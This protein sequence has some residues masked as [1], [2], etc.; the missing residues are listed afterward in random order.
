MSSFIE[1][2]KKARKVAIWSIIGMIGIWIVLS[3]FS[4][5]DSE[6]RKRPDTGNISFNGQTALKGKQ[7]FQAYNGMDCHT[8]VGNGAYFAPDLTKIYEKTGPAW[9]KAY[10][11]SPGTYPTQAIVNVNFQQMK[12]D[13]EIIET[14]LD[15]Y[16][17]KYEGAKER[18][19]RRSGIKALMPN[20]NFTGEEIDALIAFFK[21][22]SKLNTAGWPPEVRAKQSMIDHEADKLESA[23]GLIK[24]F[25]SS[26]GTSD[27]DS[28]KPSAGL[29]P[30]ANGQQLIIDL[31]C[32]ACH[33][34]DGSKLVGPSFKGLYGAQVSLENGTTVTADDAYLRKSIFEPNADLVKGYPAGVMPSFKGM[35]PDDHVSDIIS[36][37]KTL[38]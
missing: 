7:V 16:L 36:Y 37:L 9:L 23:S 20:L 5:T 8:I 28:S 30:V 14:N 10:L 35:I 29:S 38:K 32:A 34:A 15:D 33:S 11:G 18:L 31:G 27:S 17:K 6:V 4:F 3:I 19:D 25:P 22:S 21:Y 13:G 24:S 12:N 26:T 2:E 1:K